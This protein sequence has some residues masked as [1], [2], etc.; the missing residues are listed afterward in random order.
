M[1]GAIHVP[2]YIESEW[3]KIP[4]KGAE[5]N[6]WVDPFAAS[7]IFNTGLPVFLTP[8]DAT[9]QVT[10]TLE[11]ANVWANSGTQEGS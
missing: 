5:W 10:W 9:D 11:D 7:E 3:P 1:G 2:A 6:L 4:N 8:L